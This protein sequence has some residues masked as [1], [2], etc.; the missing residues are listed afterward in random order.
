[1]PDASPDPLLDPQ[2]AALAAAD[3]VEEPPGPDLREVRD[4]T[5]PSAGVP[6]RLYS[7]DLDD[8]VVVFLHGGGFVSGGLDSHDAHARR[9]CRD[10][11]RSVLA[12]DYRLAPAHPFPAAYDD[13]VAAVRWAREELGERVAVAGPSAGANLAMG[14]ALALAGTDAAPVAQL[15]VNPLVH[16]D[17]SY[18]SRTELADAYGLTSQRLEWCVEQYLGEQS[19]RDDPRFAP[20]L[21][22]DLR[23]LPPT[24]LVVAGRDPLRDEGRELGRRLG[25]AGVTVDL[26]EE[27]GMPHGFWRFAPLSDAAGSAVARMSTLFR[28]RLDAATHA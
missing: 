28:E 14:A 15:L 22:P 5:V 17:P 20:L 1:M 12:V 26:S 19:L 27:P 24:V 23:L 25:D 21:S 6:A 18:P 9:L 16:G 10:T 13:A 11:G 4:L 8:C 7:G 3:E 2:I